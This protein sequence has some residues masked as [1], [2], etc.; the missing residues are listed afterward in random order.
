VLEL[1]EDKGGAGYLGDSAG[2]GG[3]VLEDGPA[4]REQGE[5]AF[6]AAAQVALERV[7]GAGSEVEFLVSGGVFH[8]DKDSDS[9]GFVAAVGQGRHAERGGPVM[10]GDA[11]S[12]SCAGPALSVACT[13][14]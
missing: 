4:L 3:D 6:S 1:R 8:G 9:G 14:Q 2:A 11:D 5:P 7:P 13:S 12:A 10:S